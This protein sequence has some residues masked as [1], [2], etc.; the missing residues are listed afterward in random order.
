HQKTDIM[1]IAKFVKVPWASHRIM[2]FKENYSYAETGCGDSLQSEYENFTLTHCS[3]SRFDVKFP[4]FELN[5]SR[6]TPEGD[7][8][9]KNKILKSIGFIEGARNMTRITEGAEIGPEIIGSSGIY[10]YC[11][12]HISN[13]PEDITVS[14]VNSSSLNPASDNLSGIYLTMIKTN[15]SIIVEANIVLNNSNPDFSDVTAD[16]GI[17]KNMSYT[18]VHLDD[19]AQ[20]RGEETV[21]LKAMKNSGMVCVNENAKNLSDIEEMIDTNCYGGNWIYPET[22]EIDGENYYKIFSN[23]TLTMEGDPLVCNCSS[24]GD[25]TA[26]LNNNSCDVVMLTTN[27]TT[28]YGSCISN[29]GNFT[30]K[31]YDCQGHLMEGFSGGYGIHLG[32][33]SGNI[34]KNCAIKG[35]DNGIHTEYSSNN[36]FINNIV[37]FNN[38]Y[39]IYLYLSKNNQIINNRINDNDNYGI[40]MDTAS[41]HTPLIN[42]TINNNGYGVYVSS[43]RNK[44]INNTINNND[45]GIYVNSFNGYNNITRNNVSLNNIDGIHIASSSNNII[46]QNYITSNNNGIFFMDSSNNRVM[47]NTI[48]SNNIA[49]IYLYYRSDDN[50]ISY[51][52]ILNNSQAGIVMSNKESLD[53]IGDSEGNENNSLEGNEISNNNLGI[54]SKNS[55]STIFSNYVCNNT[56]MNFNSLDWHSS[57]GDYNTCNNSDGWSDLR[58]TMGCKYTCSGKAKFETTDSEVIYFSSDKGHIENHIAVDEYSLPPEGRPE[59]SFPYG[60]FSFNI[61]GISPGE[62]V[63]IVIEL[64]ED[65]PTN[66]NYY[67]YDP[68]NQAYYNISIGSNDGDNIISITL[69]DGGL[70]DDD[71]IANGVIS[72]AGGPGL[73]LTTISNCESDDDCDNGY[74]CNNSKVCQKGCNYNYSC[75]LGSYCNLSNHQCEPKSCSNDS[76]CPSIG[77]YCEPDTKVCVMGCTLN[78]SCAPWAYCNLTNHQC[79]PDSCSNDTDCQGNSYCN[80]DEG[81]CE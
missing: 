76:D 44:L 42:N 72:D 32:G 63:T 79:E 11:S 5:N 64:P 74:F 58:L 61:T 45:Y 38:N 73:I 28:I 59:A 25:C 49:G 4:I 30:N 56:D 36:T 78:E 48:N 13:I 60:F 6:D 18:L 71:G 2:V 81:V 52:K 10:S 40:Y 70:G 69:T 43:L 31:T 68:N 21:Y 35:F 22:V 67:K 19:K 8:I 39:G 66:A 7:A 37:N 33:T 75:A 15:C 65:L 46:F 77:F 62:N 80:L 17:Y 23:G 54:Y 47:N 16:A 57:Y 20:K 51:N 27:I 9:K 41:D 14:I 26:K 55:S 29:T 53:A 3:N 12:S 1:G 24:C 50:E 34:I